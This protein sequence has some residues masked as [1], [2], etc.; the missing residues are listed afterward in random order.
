MKHERT[1]LLKELSVQ[2]VSLLALVAERLF[3]WP[4]KKKKNQMLSIKYNGITA[5]KCIN[6][7]YLFSSKISTVMTE[8]K[9]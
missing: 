8:K 9:H 1:C 3:A 2:S 7:F 5:Q 4:F 6:I